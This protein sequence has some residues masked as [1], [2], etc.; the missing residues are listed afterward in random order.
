MS[1]W[2]EL[3]CDV[4][5]EGADPKN[6]LRHHCVTHAGDSPGLLTASPTDRSLIATKRQLEHE[7]R[8]RGW[9]RFRGRDDLIKWACPGCKDY[10]RKESDG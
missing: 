8:R 7:A 3:M 5:Q 2:V 9:R 4:R 10:R 6:P 1:F